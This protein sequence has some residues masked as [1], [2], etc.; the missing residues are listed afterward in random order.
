M[1]CSIVLIPL[2]LL[3][4]SCEGEVYRLDREAVPEAPR[5]P[6]APPSGYRNLENPFVDDADAAVAGAVLFEMRCADCHGDEGRGDGPRAARLDPAPADL[7]SLGDQSDG[8]LLW[9]IEVGVEGLPFDSAMP[10]FAGALTE[11]DAWR[12]VTFLRSLST[13]EE[14]PE[15]RP[16]DVAPDGGARDPTTPA[17]APGGMRAPPS[18]PPTR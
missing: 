6:I 12:V 3:A 5:D 2:G 10:A 1:R 13:P 14:D 11:D 4:V 18:Q 16:G 17:P 8:Y 7:T 9:R 15:P